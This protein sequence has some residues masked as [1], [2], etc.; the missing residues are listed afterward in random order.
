MSYA[1]EWPPLNTAR[2]QTL[3]TAQEVHDLV[4]GGQT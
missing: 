3:R 1:G 4:F 2:N